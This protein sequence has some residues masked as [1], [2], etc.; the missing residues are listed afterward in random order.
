MGISC[1]TRELEFRRALLFRLPFTLPQVRRPTQAL[2]PHRITAYLE[3]LADAAKGSAPFVPRRR[4]LTKTPLSSRRE[5]CLPASILCLFVA[6]DAQRRLRVLCFSGRRRRTRRRSE[7]KRLF[8]SLH[9]LSTFSTLPSPL[10]PTLVSSWPPLL[11][12]TG[13]SSPAPS[14]ARRPPLTGPSSPAPSRSSR[15]TWPLLL[16]GE[17]L[18][19]AA[20]HSNRFLFAG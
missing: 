14:P 16:F 8:S 13:P 6:T 2:P 12:L 19:L 7:S 1:I 10:P 17:L 20:T 9:F 18:S 11:L 4:R 3:L 5:R 15:R